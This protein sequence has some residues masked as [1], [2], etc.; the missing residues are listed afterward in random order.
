[1]AQAMT[2]KVYLFRKLVRAVLEFAM[3]DPHLRRTISQCISPA[4]LRQTAAESDRMLPPLDDSYFD[5]FEIHYGY[6]PQCT[7]A[8]LESV[9][10]HASQHPDSLP[11]TVSVLQQLRPPIHMCSRHESIGSPVGLS[12]SDLM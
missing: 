3:A 11:D 6:Q 2:K 1:M 7:P 10:F 12:D 5:F 4:I 9:T 8:F